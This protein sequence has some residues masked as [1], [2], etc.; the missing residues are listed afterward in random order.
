[1]NAYMDMIGWG[2]IFTEKYVSTIMQQM[3]RTG[4]KINHKKL[5]KQKLK[6]LIIF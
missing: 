2:N 5:Q 6:K 3:L 1:M 4:T